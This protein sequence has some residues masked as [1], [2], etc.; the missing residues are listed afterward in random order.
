MTGD[1]I[2]NL[3]LEIYSPQ[4]VCLK[5]AKLQDNELQATFM[6]SNTPYLRDGRLGHI[7]AVECLLFLNQAVLVYYGFQLVSAAGVYSQ[8]VDLNKF[9]ASHKE[10]PLMLR[11]AMVMRKSLSPGVPIDGSLRLRKERFA[12][13]LYV[14]EFDFA[15]GHGA[16]TGACLI[17]Y[18]FEPIT[19]S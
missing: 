13:R 9:I 3:L 16:C 17:G 11:I 1:E 4:N 5:S 2:R 8:Y 12:R 19:H 6:V 15:F 7:A 14:G 18:P 10:T